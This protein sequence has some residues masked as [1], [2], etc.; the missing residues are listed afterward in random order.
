MLQKIK[1]IGHWLKAVHSWKKKRH[2]KIQEIITASKEWGTD[3]TV[4]EGL[5]QCSASPSHFF[6]QFLRKSIC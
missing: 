3:T 5:N 2:Q 6:E 1:K 4:W